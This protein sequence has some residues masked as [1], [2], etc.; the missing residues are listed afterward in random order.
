L[1]SV[2]HYLNNLIE[3]N[4]LKIK[5]INEMGYINS[6]NEAISL[7]KL[8]SLLYTNYVTICNKNQLNISAFSSILKQFIS[9]HGESSDAK[10]I[11]VMRVF[12][13]LPQGDIIEIGVNQGRSAILFKTLSEYYNIGNVLCID[14]WTNTGLVQ[15]DSPVEL[16]ELGKIHIMEEVLYNF[17]LNVIAISNNNI[18][19]IRKPAS[20]AIKDYKENRE[21]ITQELGKVTY[22]GEI[23]LLHIDGNHDYK[24]VK[25]DVVNYLPLVKQNG[26]IIM[27]DY[28]WTFG[29]GPKKVADELLSCYYVNAFV[30]GNALFCKKI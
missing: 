18:N 17:L 6:K 23:A 5:I 1:S 3:K 22:T 9:I 12:A 19:Y 20:E 26:W 11:G 28:H 13:D 24:Y 30:M 15:L 16:N 7:R 21:I 29:D 27:D 25:E 14:P 2:W 10:M 4:D 8:A